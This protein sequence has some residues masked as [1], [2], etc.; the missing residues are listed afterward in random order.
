M[1]VNPFSFGTVKTLFWWPERALFLYE[2]RSKSSGKSS[3]EYRI[4]ALHSQ[5][6]KVD[7]GGLLQEKK[8]GRGEEGR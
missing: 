2:E 8:V 5:G 7:C 4:A 1:V 3:L 6:N